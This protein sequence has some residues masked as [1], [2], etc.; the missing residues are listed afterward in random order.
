MASDGT[1]N[2]RQGLFLLLAAA[3]VTAGII[4]ASGYALAQGSATV[5]RPARVPRKA[6]ATPLEMA[7][8][9][10]RELAR[11]AGILLPDPE[12]RVRLDGGLIPLNGNSSGF[13]DDFLKGPP[14]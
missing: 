8:R 9:L 11:G 14:A 13:P 12:R 5:A 3:G 6:P 4:L 2:G 7:L 10:E 1:R